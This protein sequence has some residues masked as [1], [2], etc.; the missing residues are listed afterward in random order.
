MA[1]AWYGAL[2][3]ISRPTASISA[4]AGSRR[5]GRQLALDDLSPGEVVIRVSHSSINYKDALAATGAGR[6]L[7]RYPLVGGIDLAG[8]VES[9]SDRAYRPAAMRCWSRAAACPRRAMAAMR[10]TRACRPRP[11]WRCR[12]VSMRLGHGARHRRLR[13]RARHHAH[14]DQW[15][16]P[17]LGPIA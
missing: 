9:S 4:T 11:W 8:T 1:S 15:P 2:Q 10:C 3:I 17:A 14:G 12:R 6:I 7:R 16:D 5:A 13:R